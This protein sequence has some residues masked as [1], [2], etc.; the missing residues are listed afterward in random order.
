MTSYLPLAESIDFQTSPYDNAYQSDGNM[1][2]SVTR[3][4]NST[5]FKEN[6]QSN[7]LNGTSLVHLPQNRL[8]NN[9]ILT[10]RL[11][12]NKDAAGDL[13]ANRLPANIFLPEGWLFTAIDWIEYSYSTSTTLRI[14]GKHIL[15]NNLS[16]CE[17]GEKRKTVLR[18]AGPQY[19]GNETGGTF[20]SGGTQVDLVASVNIP[21][22]H[23]NMNSGKCIPFDASV[24]GT[25]PISIR[26]QFKPPI[27]WM[28]HGE[29]ID[30]D[31]RTAI[32][33]MNN[34]WTE[35]YISCK[36]GYLA[37]GPSESIAGL[38]SRGGGSVYN[39]AFIYPGW[40]ESELFSG[41]DEG[42]RCVIQ[43]NGVLPGSLQSIDVF[44]QRETY[45]DATADFDLAINKHNENVFEE[46]KNVEITYGGQCIYRAD[47][48]ISQMLN[49]VEMPV[50]GGFDVND[51]APF[52]NGSRVAATLVPRK[53]YW[54][55]VQLSQFNEQITNLIQTGVSLNSN[56]VVITFNTPKLSELTQG[57]A[58]FPAPD[59]QPKYKMYC[60]YNYQCSL[61]T[62]DGETSILFLKPSRIMSSV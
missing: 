51:V 54:L 43:M 26:V 32:R 34:N 24:V 16:E 28:T 62:A 46:L 38:V 13:I 44:V 14:P 57:V 31:V 3:V 29:D 55:H 48:H 39:Y 19:D 45:G 1:R 50:D 9:V 18:L 11:P 53:S 2:E 30:S 8:L 12:A 5:C 60:N 22:P 35:A 20:V 40:Y 52:G 33:D 49:I 59:A 4:V 42:N 21:L 15:I 37:D 10:C 23:S 36:T 56:N 6:L 47:D 7:A 17:S 58:P 61:R 27:E 41:T 25:K